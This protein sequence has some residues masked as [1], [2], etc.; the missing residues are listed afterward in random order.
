MEKRYA[1][2]PVAVSKA[3]KIRFGDDGDVAEVEEVIPEFQVAAPVP[4]INEPAAPHR[5]QMDAK[6]RSELQLKRKEQWM[7]RQGL[8]TG[9]SVVSQASNVVPLTVPP[10]IHPER[11][12]REDK[13]LAESAAAIAAAAA[14]AAKARAPIP[15]MPTEQR[16]ALQKQRRILHSAKREAELLLATANDSSTTTEA[17]TAA[18]ELTPKT[19]N[20][21]AV[22]DTVGMA[23]D[24]IPGEPDA[25]QAVQPKK[26]VPPL[27]KKGGK[28]SN[29]EPDPKA[30]QAAL[31]YLDLFINNRKQWK[32]QKV[33][34]I[35]ILRNLYYQAM[36]TESQFQDA[37]KYM[38]DMGVRAK[39]ETITEANIIL[40]QVRTAKASSTETKDKNASDNDDDDEGAVDNVATLNINA[41]KAMYSRAKKVIKKMKEK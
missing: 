1:D 40:E 20:P 21:V 31:E 23:V 8:S 30:K 13:I 4:R 7:Q 18:H 35:W 19:V 3:K 33:R 5:H 39:E 24:E 29:Q 34:Q 38:K 22:D 17:D 32:F 16:K 41:S 37:L 25:E 27:K 2:E 6:Q 26:R 9:A 36:V 15:K 11:Q 28:E 12:S 14:A 10:T